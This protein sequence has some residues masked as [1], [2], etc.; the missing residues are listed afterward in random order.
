MVNPANS[1]PCGSAAAG[2]AVSTNAHT[3][4]RA[5][6]T[7]RTVDMITS[8]GDH[9]TF[10]DRCFQDGPIRTVSTRV[11]VE[12]VDNSERQALRAG[13]GQSA[14]KPARTACRTSSLPR[15]REG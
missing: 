15:Y 13:C 6:T 3:H 10:P 7:R 4:A 11:D 14:C 1:P 5:A 8:G 9:G 2:V 12:P